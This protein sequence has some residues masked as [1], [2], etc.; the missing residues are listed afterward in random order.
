VA[1]L[2]ERHR[3]SNHDAFQR[4]ESHRPLRL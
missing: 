4:I 3:R 1:R 2:G